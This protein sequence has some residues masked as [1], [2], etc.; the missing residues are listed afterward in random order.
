MGLIHGDVCEVAACKV[1]GQCGAGGLWTGDKMR[2]KS[3]YSICSGECTL[4]EEEGQSV[5]VCI[6][7]TNST[8]DLFEFACP[9]LEVIT[10]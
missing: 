9:L 7:T 3:S 2:E 5:C 8:R 6:P 10:D 1:W 4:R